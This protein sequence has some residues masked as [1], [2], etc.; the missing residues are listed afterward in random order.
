MSKLPEWT[1]NR[2]V[3]G[4]IIFVFT[5]IGA[6]IQGTIKWYVPIVVSLLAAFV[7]F[8]LYKR[9][10]I[11]SILSKFLNSLPTFGMVLG[12]IFLSIFG[13]ILLAGI[14][15]GLILFIVKLDSERVGVIHQLLPYLLVFGFYI[16]LIL[17]ESATQIIPNFLNAGF[18]FIKL[19]LFINLLLVFQPAER[20][21][22][23]SKESNFSL[24]AFHNAVILLLVLNLFCVF[25]TY[26]LKLKSYSTRSI[27]KKAFFAALN[28]AIGFFFLFSSIRFYVYT[29]S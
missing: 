6:S 17:I 12:K 21:F 28:N 24:E 11:Y 7:I 3:T 14:V 13:I 29:I 18:E 2:F 22:N 8:V 16:I 25:L 26:R 1:E 19:S 15:Y 4:L 5:A 9:Q 10:S 23:I 27:N 20:F